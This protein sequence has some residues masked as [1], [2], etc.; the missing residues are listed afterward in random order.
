MAKTSV[1]RFK[2]FNI[3]LFILNSNIHVNLKHIVSSL[4]ACES[5]LAFI[6]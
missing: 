6:H 4:T 1:I 3:Y 5:P 2:L